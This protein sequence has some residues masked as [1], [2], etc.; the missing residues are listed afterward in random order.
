MFRKFHAWI[1]VDLEGFGFGFILVLHGK[2]ANEKS[3]L[4]SKYGLVGLVVFVPFT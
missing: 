4:P 3:D 2:G 1:Q